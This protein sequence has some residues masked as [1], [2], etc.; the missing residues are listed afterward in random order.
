MSDKRSKRGLNNLIFTRQ[1][2]SAGSSGSF[3][4]SAESTRTYAKAFGT[5]PPP[6]R[7]TPLVN[8]TQAVL[9]SEDIK[10][11]TEQLDINSAL[12]SA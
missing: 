10:K 8:L 6:T 4:E 11:Y 7:L 9:R 1:N 5:P 12:S 2:I 3:T